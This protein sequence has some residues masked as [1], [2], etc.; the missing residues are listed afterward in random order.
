MSLA[1][2]QVAPWMLSALLALSCASS[3]PSRFYLLEAQSRSIAA[4]AADAPS[5]GVGPILFPGYLDRSEMVVRRGGE[6]ELLD[7]ERWGERLPSNFLSVLVE[8]LGARAGA[9]R[10]FGF[11][12]PGSVSLDYRLT[13][14]VSQFEADESGLVTLAVQWQ[15]VDAEGV[16][17][18]PARRSRYTEQASPGDY[19]ATAAALSR[20]V[21]AFSDDVAEALEAK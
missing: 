8:N 17:T 13:G 18:V 21:A 11:G 20:T 9:H 1:C 3:A 4:P 2:R 12:W 6:L 19:A 16:A 7:F 10:F 15:I 5:V 14:S